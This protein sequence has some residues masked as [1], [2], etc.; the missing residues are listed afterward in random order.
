[1]NTS[2]G[3]VARLMRR[4]GLVSPGIGRSCQPT[5]AA[6]SGPAE[7]V[8]RKPEQDGSGPTPDQLAAQTMRAMR[9]A[10]VRN[11]DENNAQRRA[12]QAANA[13][14]LRRTLAKGR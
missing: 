13:A 2:A 5:S 6:S 9:W 4:L 10:K 3:F 11:K 8:S 7:P 1:M 14:S 12:V